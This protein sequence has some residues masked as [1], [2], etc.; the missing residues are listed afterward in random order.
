MNHNHKYRRISLS[1]TCLILVA[2]LFLLALPVF[3]APKHTDYIS[4]PDGILSDTTVAAIKENNETLFRDN[5]VRIAVCVVDGTEGDTISDYSRNLFTSWGMSDGVL[6]VLD[7]SIP[8]YYAVQS[9]D[10]DDYLTNEA[11]KSILD[12]YME[13][14]FSTGNTDRAVMKTITALTTYMDENLPPLTPV[15]TDETTA[16]DETEPAAPTEEEPS[17]VVKFLKFLLW[18]LLILVALAVAVFVV[19]LFNDDVG[20]F[21]RTYVFRKGPTAQPPRNDYYDD[22]LYGQPGRNPNNPYSQMNRPRQSGYNQYDP[23]GD[24]N[25][26]YRQGQPQQRRPQ[27]QGQRGYS[28][29]QNGYNQ[30]YNRQYNRQYD[31]S[32][33]QQGYPQNPGRQQNPYQ[34]QGAARGQRPNG[35]G[36]RRPPQGTV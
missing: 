8:T 34:T 20:D 4:D 10:I 33:R 31:P 7:M 21:V 16:D 2:T 3:A 25:Q 5:E 11:L 22:R 18:L 13:A 32:Y 29:N 12:T 17:G 30:Q 1:V 15:E 36:N 9:V 35:N 14:D 26:Q 23:S 19:A 28:Q 6:L 24:Y 27:N